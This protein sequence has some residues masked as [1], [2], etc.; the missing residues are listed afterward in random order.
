[1]KKKIWFGDEPD[2]PLA[3]RIGLGVCWFILF[4]MLLWCIG[5]VIVLKAKGLT[6]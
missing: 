4:V 6:G 3:S 2:M 1:M 5:I